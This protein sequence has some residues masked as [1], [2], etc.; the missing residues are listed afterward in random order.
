MTITLARDAE[1]FELDDRLPVLPLRDVVIFP[2]MVIPLLVGRAASLA[3]V[4]AALAGDRWIF[5]VAQRARR[6]PLQPTSFAWES[7]GACCRWPASPTARRKCC[8]KA[9]RAR[10]S[11]ATR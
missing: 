7:P 9:S 8:S 4:E 5:L 11:R 6:I 10:R 1:Q 3:A 2:Y